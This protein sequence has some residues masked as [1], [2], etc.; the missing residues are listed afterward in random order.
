VAALR[1]HVGPVK[2]KKR[3]EALGTHELEIVVR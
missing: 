3:T 1:M 2:K